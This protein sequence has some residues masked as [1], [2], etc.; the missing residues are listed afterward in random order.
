[1][2]VLLLPLFF[3]FTGLRTS[4]GLMEGGQLWICGLV[5]F[6][7][8]V[9]KLVGTAVAARVTGLEWLRVG[10]VLQR[11]RAFQTSTESN[12]LI[13]ELRAFL[14][15]ATTWLTNAQG[16][17]I[18]CGSAFPARWWEMRRGSSTRCRFSIASDTE[19]SPV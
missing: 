19:K 6:V 18:Y 9:G 14:S 17:V 15:P 3:A 5:T 2:V 8:I 13:C 16:C 7:A 11:T 4:V 10:L 12:A 1:M